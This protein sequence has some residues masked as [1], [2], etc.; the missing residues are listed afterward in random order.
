MRLKVGIGMQHKK[1]FNR[2]GRK[3]SHRRAMHRN[4]VTS[5]IRHDRIETTKA[6]ALEIR[7]TTEKLISRARVDNVHNRRIV[8]RYL[9]DKKVLN[10]LFISLAPLFQD[11]PG[12]YTRIIKK[13]KR[14]GD[15][16]EMVIIEFVE[17]IETR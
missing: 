14:S 4:M 12:G 1:G 9:F 3:S 2:L 5:L 16:A 17:K 6:K 15:A 7:R 8:S 13:G 11:R 10:R